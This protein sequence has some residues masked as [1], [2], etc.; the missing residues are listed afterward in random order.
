MTSL[1]SAKQGLVTQEACHE[2]FHGPSLTRGRR[3]S[4]TQENYFCEFKMSRVFE[5][6]ND[7]NST[8][9][10]KEIEVRRRKVILKNKLFMAIFVTL[11][12][13]FSL[14]FLISSILDNDF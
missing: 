2:I 8:V 5:R 3:D 9:V 6:E 12:F 14:I 11:I 10:E 13:I 1:F 7:L 4:R